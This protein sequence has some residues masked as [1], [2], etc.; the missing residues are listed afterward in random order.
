LLPQPLVVRVKT[1]WWA[2]L[3]SGGLGAAL[4]GG[5]SFLVAFFVLRHT[6]TDQAAASREAAGLAAA[7]ELQEALAST[8]IA[9]RDSLTESL[10]PAAY[11]VVIPGDARAERDGL[12][13]DWTLLLTR[14]SIA[15]QNASLQEMLMETQLVLR[16][17]EQSSSS[18]YLQRGETASA[19]MASVSVAIS[20]Y[21][22]GEADFSRPAL[23]SWATGVDTSDLWVPIHDEKWMRSN[24]ERES[25]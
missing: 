23:P 22:R 8:Y 20:R 1:D 16:A 4:G 3:L 6:R 18:Q 15:V 25:R 5:I 24:S 2:N 19:F 10:D 17:L 14:K 9:Y 7:E 13:H 21:R 12:L 11:N